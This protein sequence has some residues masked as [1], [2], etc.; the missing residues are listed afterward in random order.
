MAGFQQ[1]YASPA[2]PPMPQAANSKPVP[3]PGGNLK[4]LNEAENP[5]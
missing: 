3:Y 1:S 2:P 5:I 4:N